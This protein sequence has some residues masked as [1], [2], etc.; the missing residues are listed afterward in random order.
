M[1]VSR[2]AIR[3]LGTR[4]VPKPRRWCYAHQ[5]ARKGKP[6]RLHAHSPRNFRCVIVR[7]F[8]ATR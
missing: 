5:T 2:A 3:L 1:V 4:V 6:S 8:D 7:D